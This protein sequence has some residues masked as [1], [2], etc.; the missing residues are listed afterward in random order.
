MKRKYLILFVLLIPITVSALSFN[1]DLYFGLQENKD[2]TRLQEFLTERGF[3]NGPITGNFISLTS[4]AAKKFQSSFSITPIS[5]YFGPKSKVVA[6][7]L[8]AERDVLNISTTTNNEVAKFVNPQGDDGNL[9]SLLTEQIR[10]LQQQLETLRQ[11]QIVLQQQ[12]QTLQQIQQQT[13]VQSPIPTTQPQISMKSLTIISPMSNK[14]LGREYESYD[15]DT[16]HSV[17]IPDSERP[18]GFVFPNEKNYIYI[19]AVVRDDGGNSVRDKVCQIFATDETQNKTI[20]ATGDVTKITH[21]DGSR[22]RVSFYSFNYEFKTS[23][24]HTI[25]F[26]C[27]GMVQSVELNVE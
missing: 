3:Y 26:E 18:A 6:N 5:G 1:D 11:Q 7:K 19:G 23:G 22:E 24:I 4:T 17:N 8:F 13:L 2:V 15:W 21:A 16:L 25:R 27:D 12:S 9:I 20:N 10:I 14:G